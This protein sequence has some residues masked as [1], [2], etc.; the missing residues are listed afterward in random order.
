ML[1]YFINN[2]SETLYCSIKINLPLT[3]VYFSRSTYIKNN[4]K[5]VRK[6]KIKTFHL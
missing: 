5:A 1:Y 4:L 2:F 6:Q 3:K